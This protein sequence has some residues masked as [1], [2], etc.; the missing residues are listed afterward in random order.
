[1]RRM[2]RDVNRPRSRSRWREFVECQVGTE[3]VFV[4]M[5]TWWSFR[6]GSVARWT[7]RKQGKEHRQEE[8]NCQDVN[9]VGNVDH[10]H[11]GYGRASKEQAPRRVLSKNRN[12]GKLARGGQT[13][14]RGEASKKNRQDE[15]SYYNVKDLLGAG[16]MGNMEHQQQK[17][18]YIQGISNRKS[19]FK[20]QNGRKVKKKKSNAR[21]WW[22]FKEKTTR[23]VQFLKCKRPTGRRKHEERGTLTKEVIVLPGKNWRTEEQKS[24]RTEEQTN[25]RT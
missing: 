10:W 12:R 9:D 11:R 7:V 14:A 24:R 4:G 13:R 23:W 6:G 2:I 5:G 18:L 22:S 17:W 20:K 21:T 25:R 1:M 15:S 8:S 3:H 16:N 19:R